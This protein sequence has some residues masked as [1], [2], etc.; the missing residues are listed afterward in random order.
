MHDFLSDLGKH[1]GKVKAK[2][3]FVALVNA[4]NLSGPDKTALTTGDLTAIQQQLGN[5]KGPCWVL[6]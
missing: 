3:D 5:H 1:P 4:S 6:V 2:D